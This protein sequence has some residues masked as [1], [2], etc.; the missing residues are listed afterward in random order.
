MWYSHSPFLLPSRACLPRLR[1][2]MWKGGFRRLTYLYFRIQPAANRQEVPSTVRKPTVREDRS[3]AVQVYPSPCP[4]RKDQGQIGNNACCTLPDQVPHPPL[5]V[6]TCIIKPKVDRP[7][8]CICNPSTRLEE[9]GGRW[10][11]IDRHKKGSNDCEKNCGS[12][13]TRVF[14]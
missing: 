1:R 5:T 3:Q 14:R 4:C 7:D 11:P 9:G 6:S 2:R 8:P 13:T 10:P 12:D